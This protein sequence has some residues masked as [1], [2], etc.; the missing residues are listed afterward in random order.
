MT[1]E[2]AIVAQLKAQQD[3]MNTN[4]Q[5]EKEHLL[6][7]LKAIQL[8]QYKACHNCTLAESILCTKDCFWYQ[9]K[10]ILKGVFHEI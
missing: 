2:Q 4:F 1:Y 6:S 7:A 8:R 9:V 10:I 3:V 5:Q